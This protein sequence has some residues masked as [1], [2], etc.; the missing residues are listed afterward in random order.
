MSSQLYIKYIFIFIL[1]LLLDYFI[2]DSIL[3]SL[4]KTRIERE[5]LTSICEGRDLYCLIFQIL[6]ITLIGNYFTDS[7]KKQSLEND[8]YTLFKINGTVF[9]FKLL[10][11]KILIL[12]R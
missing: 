6:I 5:I 9:I 11:I 10:L 3:V 12:L 8:V 7:K 1:G 2:F 4:T